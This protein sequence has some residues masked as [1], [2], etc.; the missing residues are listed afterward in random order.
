MK[1]YTTCVT[2]HQA[3]QLPNLLSRPRVHRACHFAPGYLDRLESAFLL[4]VEAQDSSAADGLA[5]TLD[6]ADR[7]PGASLASAAVSYARAGWPVHPLKV[8]SKEPASEHGFDDASTDEKVIESTWNRN[9]AFNI[10]V[11]TGIAFDVIDFDLTESPEVIWEWV[12]LYENPLAECDAIARTPRG[13][14]I[15]I[16]PRKSGR[17]KAKMPVSG[18]RVPGLDYRGKG[19]YVV[20]PPSVRPNGTYSWWVAPS[21]RLFAHV[22]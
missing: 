6:A 5:A 16:L 14:H 8:G 3:M 15:Y 21:P 22:G 19:G 11:A 4:A 17:N 10:G 7:A 9:A 13:Y 20:V 12:R 18:H 2:C 1:I